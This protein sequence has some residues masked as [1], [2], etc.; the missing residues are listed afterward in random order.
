[1]EGGGEFSDF[2]LMGNF[3]SSDFSVCFT[4][5]SGCKEGSGIFTKIS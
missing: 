5:E 3:D 4:S 2:S 1:M